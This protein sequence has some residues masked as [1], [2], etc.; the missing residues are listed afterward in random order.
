LQLRLKSGDVIELLDWQMRQP[1]NLR[2]RSPSGTDVWIA[3]TPDIADYFVEV[4]L[5]GDRLLA[6]SFSGYRLV[7]D[8]QTG[9]TL[10]KEFV[11]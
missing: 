6:T 1:S 10:S 5:D 3:E 7:I 4:H 2:R 11:K 8:T 9:R